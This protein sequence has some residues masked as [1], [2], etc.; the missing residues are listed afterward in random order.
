MADA[1]IA[2]DRA[3]FST[4]FA[5]LG[6]TPE[7]CSSIFFERIMSKEDAARMLGDEGWTPTAAEA[8]AAGMISEVV[9]HE[10]HMDFVQKT[11][12]EWIATGRE[13]TVNKFPR[14]DALVEELQRCNEQESLDLAA[15][16]LE[17]KFLRKQ[18]EFAM[19][20]NKPKV[21]RFFKMALSS[22]PV[23]KL[24]L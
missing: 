1:C 19:E 18:Y 23:W 12:E 7:G 11:A 24:L 9:P 17:E 4:P 13:R 21:A 20:K 10:E 22:R 14:T 3:T 16:F 6:V 5:R 15:A 8:K 2:S